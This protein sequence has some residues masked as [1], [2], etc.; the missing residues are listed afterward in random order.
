MI[1]KEIV[2]AAKEHMVAMSQRAPPGHETKRHM[3]CLQ[4]LHDPV[5]FENVFC[6]FP[7]VSWSL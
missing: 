5:V 2:S 4:G 6:P 3:E 1:R 7:W